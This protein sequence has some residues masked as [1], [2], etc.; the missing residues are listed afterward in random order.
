MECGTWKMEDGK[1]KMEYGGWNKENG[2]WC[3]QDGRWKMEDGVCTIYGMWNAKYA[4]CNLL[5]FIPVCCSK[6]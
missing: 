1:W 2:I 3:V 5:Q 6:S 4:L